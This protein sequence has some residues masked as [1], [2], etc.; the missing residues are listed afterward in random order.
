MPIG[1]MLGAQTLRE[2]LLLALAA[3]L[4][5]ALPWRERRSPLH[6]LLLGK[7]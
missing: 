6:E 3:Q 5:E 2:D 1:V 4:E 7:R